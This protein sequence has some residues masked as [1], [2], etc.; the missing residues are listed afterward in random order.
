MPTPDPH[1]RKRQPGGAGA[2]G[3]QAGERAFLGGHNTPATVELPPIAP[4]SQRR[5][6]PF[7]REIAEAIAAGRHPNVFA[8]AGAGAWDRTTRRRFQHGPASATVIP[9]DTAPEALRW[10][11]GLDSICLAADDLARPDAVRTAQAIV[12]AGV[13]CVV[14]LGHNFIVRSAPPG[15]GQCR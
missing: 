10:P 2:E 14:V 4:A 15:G 9:A 6:I 3:M 1:M 7:G 8:F 13:R 5:L 12:T 11:D